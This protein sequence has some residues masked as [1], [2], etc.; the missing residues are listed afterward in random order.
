[1]VSIDC[2]SR[3]PLDGTVFLDTRCNNQLHRETSLEVS[4]SHMQPRKPFLALVQ[5]SG[6]SHSLGA[7]GAAVNLGHKGGVTSLLQAEVGSFVILLHCSLTSACILILFL[8]NLNKLLL[9]LT[10][11]YYAAQK[12]RSWDC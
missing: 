11:L 9:Y 3:K 2:Y 4:P 12:D 1:M 6:E 7:D 8:Q 5:M 10:I